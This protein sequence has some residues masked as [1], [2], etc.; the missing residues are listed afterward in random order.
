M[1]SGWSLT[2][3]GILEGIRTVYKEC[4]SETSI[5][6]IARVLSNIVDLFS[7]E[8]RGFLK[9]DTGYHDLMHTLQVIPPFVGIIDGRNKSQHTPKISKELFDLGIIA[10]LLHD[11]GY[12]KAEGDIEGTGGKYTFVHIQRSIDFSG[13]YLSQLGFKE[14]KINSV[15]NF[16]MCTGVVVDYEDLPFGSQEERI[17]GY[18]LGTADLLGQMS[19]DDYPEKLP[20]LYREFE[21]SY[22]YE[23]METLRKKGVKIFAS[24]NDLIRNTPTFYEFDVM[25]RFE[26]MGS[27]YKYLTYHFKD[28]RNHY[29]EAIEENVRKIKRASSPQ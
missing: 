21:E 20:L 19:A 26:K 22:H 18:T 6:I 23:G 7:G 12:M 9:C 13:H 8:K 11:T 29:I 14:N 15:R 2:Q 10:V 1:I 5:D 24:E 25:R 16:I 27:Q 17:V 4:Y 3:K 28:A